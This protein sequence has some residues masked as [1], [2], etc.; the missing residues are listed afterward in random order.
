MTSKVVV[1]CADGEEVRIEKRHRCCTKPGRLNLVIDPELKEWA[2]A[3]ASR[4]H[5]TLTAIITDH[6]IS[7]RDKEHKKCAD[8]DKDLIK[9]A[10]REVMQEI[11]EEDDDG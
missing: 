11:F 1:E 6:L 5:T 4:K 9:E 3:Y 2:H 7:I 10:V 8:P